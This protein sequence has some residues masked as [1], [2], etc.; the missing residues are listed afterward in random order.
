M[1]IGP[2]FFAAPAALAILAALPLLFLILRATPPAPKHEFF[3]PLPLLFGLRTEEESRKRAPLWLVLLRAFA[4]AL[5][6]LGFARPSLAPQAAASAGASGPILIVVDDGWPSAPSWANIRAVADDAI[7]EAER[8]KQQIF[9][10]TTAPQR[11]PRE[12]GEALS[13]VDARGLMARLT[14]RPWRA[15]RSDALARLPKKPERFSKIVWL[16]DGLEDSGAVDLGRA[17]LARGPVTA[18]LPPRLSRAVMSASVTGEGIDAEIR[19]PPGGASDG[20]LAAETLEGRSLA[21][22]QFRFPPG[23]DM[24]TARVTLPPEIAARAARVRIVGEASAG[25]TRLLAAGSGRPLVG[26]V[27]AGGQNQPLLS[28]NYYVERAI[29]PFASARRGEIKTLVDSGAQAIVLPDASRISPPDAAALDKW[30]RDGGLLVRFAGPRLANAADSLTPVRLRPGA[31]TLG[32]AMA[33]EKPQSFA[34]FTSDSP[35][36]GLQPSPDVVVSRQ[37][38]VEPA[39]EREAR[40]WARLSDGAPAV[41]A[42]A[43]GKGLIVLFHITAGPAWSNLPLSGLYVDMLRRTLQFAGR[44][45]N[46]VT[47]KSSTGPWSPKLLMDGYG[48]LAPPGVDAKAIPPDIFPDAIAKP[49]TPPGFY[50]RPGSPGAALDAASPKESLAPIV[51]AQGIVRAGLEGA[52]TKQLGGPFLGFAALLIAL[53][54]ILALALAGRLPRLPQRV[55]PAAAALLLMLAIAPARPAHAAADE[56]L[57]THL[58]YIRTG[59]SRRDSLTATGLQALGET[60]TARTAVEPGAPVG[61][62]PARDDLSPYPLIYWSAP[63]NPQRLS[64][65]AVQNLDRY[66]RLGGMIFLDTRDPG[67][68]GGGGPAAILL[69]GVDTPPL[70]QIAPDNVLSRSFYLL[71]TY[72]GRTGPA[73]I[74][75]ETAGA[76]AARDGVPSLIIGDGD[77]A[78]TWAQ[79]TDADAGFGGNA[80]PREMSLRFGV[81][82]VMVALTGNYKTDQ[83]H[84]PTLLQRLG[85]EK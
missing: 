9:I 61:V 43:R 40:V 21:A 34:P 58:A 28:D 13:P 66:M 22:G 44:V 1:T 3:P 14:P 57:E 32:G 39:S 15:D 29:A 80:T 85:R 72:P 6:I 84:I 35:F 71:K 8:A 25:A 45:Q 56:T 55:A 24:V 26:L 48:A 51:L 33:W 27:D 10:L 53:D 83:V 11:A 41:T 68:T 81:N 37:V 47:E 19:R 62:D 52:S 70:E 67:R 23:G 7:A 38:L 65:A 76:A 79:V 31:R 20:A 49:E 46:A 82:L 75:A 4:A 74:F 30:L 5:M 69:Q 64:D 54:L 50:E 60:L 18:R 17:L 42:A 16:T 63:D 77:W 73:R 2:L 78:S 12:A 59:D 36:S